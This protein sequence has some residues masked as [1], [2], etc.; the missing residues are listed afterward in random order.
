MPRPQF[1]IRTLLWLTL[2]AACF[3]GGMLFERELARRNQP[4]QQPPSIWF[5]DDL[6]NFPAGPEYRVS[7]KQRDGNLDE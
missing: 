7:K 1:T 6:Q 3:F 5:G 4:P 2:A